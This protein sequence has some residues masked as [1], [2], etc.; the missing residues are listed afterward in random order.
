MNVPMIEVMMHTPPI[1]KGRLIS[2]SASTDLPSSKAID[3][4]V[5][6]SVTT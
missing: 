1:S 5:T 2:A 3:T 6:P 4:I